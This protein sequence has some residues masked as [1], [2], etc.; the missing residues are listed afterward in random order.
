MLEN[1]L[2]GEISKALHVN[3]GPPSEIPLGLPKRENASFSSLIMRGGGGAF[4][5]F[6]SSRTSGKKEK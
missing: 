1:P 6:F 4:V 3:W 5:F 2:F